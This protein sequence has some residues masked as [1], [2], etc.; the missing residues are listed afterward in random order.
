M[1]PKY[2]STQAGVGDGKGGGGGGESIFCSVSIGSILLYGSAKSQTSAGEYNHACQI[3]EASKVFLKTSYLGLTSRIAGC[4]WSGVGWGIGRD[5]SIVI[6]RRKLCKWI[7]GLHTFIWMVS[8]PT[9]SFIIFVLFFCLI[10]F[11]TFFWTRLHVAVIVEKSARW[12][13]NKN[14]LS[15]ACGVLEVGQDLFLSGQFAFKNI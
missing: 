6:L 5:L 13:Q 1:R 15:C 9:C 4:G 12:N 7:H 3:S 10:F 8:C 11:S 14:R 2:Q